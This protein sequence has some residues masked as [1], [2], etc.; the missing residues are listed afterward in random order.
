MILYTQ[1]RYIWIGYITLLMVTFS[2][3]KMTISDFMN[4]GLRPVKQQNQKPQNFKSCLL[5]FARESGVIHGNNT[6]LTLIDTP[7]TPTHCEKDNRDR[8]HD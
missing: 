1:P 3:R 2:A 8:Q 7:P 5:R 6:I 4:R